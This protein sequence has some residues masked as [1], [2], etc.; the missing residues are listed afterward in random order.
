MSQINAAKYPKARSWILTIPHEHFLPYLPPSVAYIR[1]Q[2]EKGGST[3]YLHWQLVLHFESQ[4]RLSHVRKLFG[5]WH[6]EP[7]LSK[8]AEDYV[9]KEETAIAGTRFVIASTKFEID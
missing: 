7:T 8:K 2:L 6:A 5:P 1:G 9:W 4:Q 3:E